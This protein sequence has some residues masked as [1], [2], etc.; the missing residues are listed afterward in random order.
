[1]S[2]GRWLRAAA[3]VTDVVRAAALI[4]E[5][6][7]LAE[8][9]G[10]HS[11]WNEGRGAHSY[12]NEG[13]SANMYFMLL[14]GPRAAAPITKGLRAAALILNSFIKYESRSAQAKAAAL[15]CIF[16]LYDCFGL[17][18]ISEVSRREISGIS[19]S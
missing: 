1:M 15:G 14:T 5:F 12:W 3:L 13:R 2:R 16:V 11:Y 10:A 17:C 7:H 9:R 8:G 6:K 4:L 18:N 19:M